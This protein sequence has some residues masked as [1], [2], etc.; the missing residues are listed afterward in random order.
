MDISTLLIDGNKWKQLGCNLIFLFCCLYDTSAYASQPVVARYVQVEL[1][2]DERILSLAE[3]EV[4]SGEK[5]ISLQGKAKQVNTA[6][7]GDA[8][9]AIDGNTSGSYFDKTVTHTRSGSFVW[10][11]LDLGT[12]QVI[13]RII[14]YNRTDCCSERINP[15]RVLLLNEAKE[16]VWENAIISNAGRYDFSIKRTISLLPKISPNLLRNASFR[17]R[18]NP[19][20]PD[21]WDLHHAAAT[22]I[23][24]LHTHYEVDESLK[25]PVVGTYVLKIH[26]TEEDFRHTMLI[27]CRLFA[28]LSEGYYTFSAYIKSDRNG[29]E[30]RVAPGWAIGKEIIRKLSTKWKRY[31]F[32]FNLPA[33]GKNTLQPIL[34]FPKK[35]AYFIAAA[36]LERGTSSSMFQPSYEDTRTETVKIPTGVRVVL[37]KN[38]RAQKRVPGF[39]NSIFVNKQPFYIIGI[40][41]QGVLTDWYLSE[42]K[43]QGINTLFY[44][45]RPNSQGVFD[46]SVISDIETVLLNAARHDLKVIVGLALA[47]VKPA[48]WRVCVSS[49]SNLIKWLKDYPMV[50]GWYPVDEPAAHTWQ[51]NEL[52]EIYTKLKELDPDKFIFVNWAYDGVPKEVGQQPRGTLDATDLYSVSYYPFAGHGRS[53]DGFTETTIRAIKTARANKK[54]F[55]SWLQLYGGMDAWREPTGVE[56]NYM[57]YLNFVYG[58][59]ISYWDTKSNSEATWSRVKQINYE[60]KMLAENLFLNPDAQE[61]LPPVEDGNFIYSAWKKE[62]SVFMIVVHKGTVLEEFT[63][64]TSRL[65]QNIS[66]FIVRSMFE[67]RNVILTNSYIKEM[68]LPFG[69]RVYVLRSNHSP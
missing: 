24:N 51:D 27:P 41:A 66:S 8:P 19:P 1:P 53:L 59:M 12:E 14:L 10:W 50:I 3:V 54:S 56:L 49:F 15:A 48:N 42:I 64:D 69:T 60:G 16:I 45:R 5:M 30:L 21:Y 4:Y 61:I 26:N 65:I 39:T 44:Y 23:K 9:R 13:T 63:Y 11:E 40:V 43:E 67:S 34:R 33:S 57:A 35:G 2:G 37:H 52:M 36:Q 62:G 28:D 25:S 29:T 47:G 7:G 55:H 58:G 6:C 46:D 32:T 22:K 68:F 18:T 31:S 38:V 20:I 17:Q